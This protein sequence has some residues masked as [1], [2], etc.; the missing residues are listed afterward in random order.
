MYYILFIYLSIL[1]IGCS[2]TRPINSQEDKKFKR[3][4][5]QSITR[6]FSNE[7]E[8]KLLKKA[9]SIYP[10]RDSVLKIVPEKEKY[11]IPETG[12]W[13]VKIIDGIKIP[14]AITT[15]AVNYYSNKIEE[16]YNDS[17]SFIN[18]AKFTYKAEVKFYEAFKI[19]VDRI[20]L[21]IKQPYEANNVFVAEMFLEWGH[22]CGNM[23]CLWITARR[24]VVFDF[25][26]NLL[27]VFYDKFRSVIIC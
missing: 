25:Q 4:F 18:T 16:L 27:K 19:D 11:L 23:C 1:L 24:V 2:N 15:E 13:F 9:E 10:P 8:E 5:T 17:T 3:E 21:A 22:G 12:Y 26:G 6:T 14:Y 7:F 20:S